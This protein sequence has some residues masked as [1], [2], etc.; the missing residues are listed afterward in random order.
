MKELLNMVGIDIEPD[1]LRN[2]LA[3]HLESDQIQVTPPILLM[4]S[5]LNVIF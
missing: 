4:L 3:N 5:S 2:T 1:L